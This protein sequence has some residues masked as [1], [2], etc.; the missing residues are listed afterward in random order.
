MYTEYT[1]TRSTNAL[2]RNHPIVT[3]LIKKKRS[4]DGI[5]LKSKRA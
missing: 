1:L 5:R 4:D 2:S 3:F